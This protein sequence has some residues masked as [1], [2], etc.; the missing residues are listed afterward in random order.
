MFDSFREARKERHEKKLASFVDKQMQQL[1]AL[2]YDVKK[3][4]PYQYRINDALD[5][6]P[7][8]SKYH[9]IKRNKRGRYGNVITF[10]KEFNF[11]YTKE[12][13]KGFTK[14]YITIN[15]DASVCGQTQVATYA[16]YIKTTQKAETIT[17][18]LKQPTKSSNNAELAAIAN[19]LEYVHK[20]YTGSFYAIVVNSDSLH[21]IQ[22][23]QKGEQS[24]YV[25]KIKETTEKLKKSL[26][27]EFIKYKHVKGHS[28][29]KSGRARANAL[30]HDKAINLMRQ[31]RNEKK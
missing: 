22:K 29:E 11:I 20:N 31:K 16:F 4:T 1:T 19:A 9:D 23:I 17:G 10:V 21:G 2:L 13:K 6:F 18:V 24:I 28:N 14:E 30:A 5:I 8:S 26:S 12:N 7:I 3:L 27:I 15:T 25:D